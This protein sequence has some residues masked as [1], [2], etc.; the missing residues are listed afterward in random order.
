M[1]INIR[2]SIFTFLLKSMDIYITDKF[3]IGKLK[4]DH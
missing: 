1:Y 4:Q 3:N 2:I